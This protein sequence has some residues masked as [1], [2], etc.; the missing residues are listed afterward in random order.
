MFHVYCA[1]NG[2]VYNSDLLKI[3]PSMHTPLGMLVPIESMLRVRQASLVYAKHFPG[4]A[5]N[6]YNLQSLHILEEAP[7]GS[8]P[9]CNE[10]SD[11][12]KAYIKLIFTNKMHS[13]KV[14]HLIN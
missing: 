10:S 7:I 5:A 4:R 14:H 6:S 12:P 3:V 2:R 11:L 9:Y 1:K 13:Q 8:V